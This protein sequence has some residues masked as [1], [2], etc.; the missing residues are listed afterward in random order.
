MEKKFERDTQQRPFS[1]LAVSR[2]EIS[3]QRVSRVGNKNMNLQNP[4]SLT[5]NYL[6]EDKEY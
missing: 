6:D 3:Q 4:S 2:L 1:D 5:Q